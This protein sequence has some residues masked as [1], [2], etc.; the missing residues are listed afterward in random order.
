MLLLCQHANK[1]LAF[2]YNINVLLI[3][4]RYINSIFYLL[5]IDMVAVCSELPDLRE[6]RNFDVYYY[7]HSRQKYLKPN[8]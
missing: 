2:L 1:M 7:G 5:C 8:I 4:Y 3:A 6:I